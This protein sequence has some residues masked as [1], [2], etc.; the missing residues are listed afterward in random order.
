MLSVFSLNELIALFIFSAA[1]SFSPGPNTMLTTAIASNEGIRKTIPFALAVP[2]GWLL[3][4]LSCGLGIGAMIT[5]MPSLRLSIK[6]LGCAYLIWLAYKLCRTKK[7]H[8][9]NSARLNINFPKGVLLQFLNIKVWLLAITITGTWIIDAEGQ[10]STNPNERLAL[11]CAIV[12]FMAFTSN[13][14]YA[15]AGAL[16]RTWLGSGNRLAIFNYFLAFLL[17]ATAIWTLCI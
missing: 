2:I 14:T 17:F 11:A 9:V 7:L 1:M 3:I 6:L 5:E 4:M 13:M 15:L 16:F 12:M 10:A 8:E